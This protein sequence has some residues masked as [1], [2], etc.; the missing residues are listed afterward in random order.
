MR[1]TKIFITGGD[2]DLT[3][4]IVHLVLARLPERARGEGISMIAVPK[5]LPGANGTAGEANA[6]G[7]SSIE[8]KMG[9]KG[10]P[11]AW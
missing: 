8:Q 10:L 1:G 2:Q 11:P 4:N 7:V 9:I 6:L 5:R 3:S